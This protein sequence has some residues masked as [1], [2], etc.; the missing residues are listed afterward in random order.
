MNTRAQAISATL[1]RRGM[2]VPTALP[3]GLSGGFAADP[4]RQALWAAFVRKNDL[5]MI[6]LADVVNRI[7]SALEPAID[8]AARTPKT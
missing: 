2:S 7:R 1:T 6:P 3:M 8:L 4:S 5:A